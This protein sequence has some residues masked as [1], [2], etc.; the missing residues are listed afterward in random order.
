MLRK[1]RQSEREWK[2]E[3]VQKLHNLTNQMSKSIKF[4][5]RRLSKQYNRI[6]IFT[7]YFNLKIFNK[8]FMVSDSIVLW[9]FW[10]FLKFFVLSTDFNPNFI[11][12]FLKFP[13]IS[14]LFFIF[15]LIF[16]LA[17]D[18]VNVN[19]NVVPPILNCMVFHCG[20]KFYF[21]HLTY[22]SLNARL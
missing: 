7:K 3:R 20:Q 9:N 8:A 5:S 22:N 11:L 15:I 17:G 19:Q 6:L 10:T 13:W 14:Y 4:G 18:P 21:C 12:L 1:G 16:V 2:L